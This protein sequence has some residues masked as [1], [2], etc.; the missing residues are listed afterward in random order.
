MFQTIHRSIQQCTIAE[1]R[2]PW[3]HAA[4]ETKQFIP[5][6]VGTD[7]EAHSGD[8]IGCRKTII[9]RAGGG[10]AAEAE[11]SCLATSVAAEG[12]GPEG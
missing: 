7:K 2:I 4:V 1:H 8:I 12:I 3:K 11:L 9:A 6:V 10:A 5:F